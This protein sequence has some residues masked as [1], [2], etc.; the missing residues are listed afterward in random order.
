[1]T[2]A[3]I[4]ARAQ[5]PRRTR[6]GRSHPH[7]QQR[8]DADVYAGIVRAWWSMHRAHHEHLMR[9]Y[10]VRPGFADEVWDRDDVDPKDVLEVCARIITFEDFRLREHA[11]QTATG[12]ALAEV[13]DPHRSW[14]HPLTNTPELGIHFWQLVLV[15]IELR[16]I[17]PVGDP[18]PLQYGQFPE[19]AVRGR[20]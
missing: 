9:T 20:L 12:T 13:L 16:C 4:T 18:P 17:G 10:L 11:T 15:P 3:T 2:P 7:V 1:M 5:A 8:T 6:E 14:W 19:R